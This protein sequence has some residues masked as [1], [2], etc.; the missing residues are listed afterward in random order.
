[1]NTPHSGFPSVEVLRIG[2]VRAGRLGKALAWSLSRSGLPVS[3]VASTALA[4]ARTL[5]DASQ[6]AT[7]DCAPAR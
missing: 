7:G 4:D 5:A 2:F 3:A 6:A 1:M